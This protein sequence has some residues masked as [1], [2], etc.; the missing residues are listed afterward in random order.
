MKRK[1]LYT[2]TGEP[3]RIRCYMQKR[4][5]TYDYITVVYTHASKAG[6]PVGTVLFRGMSEDPYH[7]LGYGMGGE[8]SRGSFNPGGSRVSFSEL[9]K[10]CQDLVLRDYKALWE[11]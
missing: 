6:F 8:G 10:N 7:P 9:P 4:R 11:E 5:T 1:N 2:E 3:R